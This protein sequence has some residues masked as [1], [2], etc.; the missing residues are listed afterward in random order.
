VCLCVL[1]VSALVVSVYLVRDWQWAYCADAVA[2]PELYDG[3]STYLLWLDSRHRHRSCGGY[4]VV[5][6]AEQGIEL[7]DEH[8]FNRSGNQPALLSAPQHKCN[9]VPVYHIDV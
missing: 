3:H 1:G 8:V 5:T 7:R 9:P 4:F 6:S 2:G